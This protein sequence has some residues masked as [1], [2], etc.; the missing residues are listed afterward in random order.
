MFMV[1]GELLNEP[2][3]ISDGLL[4]TGGAEIRAQVATWTVLVTLDVP[5]P[6]RDLHHKL[7]GF[8]TVLAKLYAMSPVPA[9]VRQEWEQR[10]KD[11]ELSMSPQRSR[12]RTKR[13]LF[14]IIGKVSTLLFGTANEDQVKEC[15]RYI[16]KARSMS[17]QISHAVTDLVTV[18]NQSHHELVRN[19][20][21]LRAVED[22]VTQLKSEVDQI[23]RD[24]SVQEERIRRIRENMRIAQYL[25]ALESIHNLWLRSHDRY[26][27]QRASLELGWLTEEI[28]PPEE[29][30]TILRYGQKEGLYSPR[31]EWYYEHVPIKPLWSDEER[32]VFEVG[33]PF[34]NNVEYLRYRIWTWPVPQNTSDFAIQMQSPADVAVD[35]QSGGIFEPNSCIGTRPA[36]CRTGAVYGKGKL[37]CPRGIISGDFNQR[38]H[39]KLTVTQ[40]QDEDSFATELIPGLFVIYTIGEDYVTYCPGE[41]EQRRQLV[42]GLYQLKVRAGCRIVGRDWTIASM[43]QRSSNVTLQLPTV[44]IIPMDLPKLI[45]FSTLQRQLEKPEWKNLPEIKDISIK[46]LQIDNDLSEPITWGSHGGH[47]A[48]TLI[49]VIIV[50]VLILCGVGLYVL[51]FA[52]FKRGKQVKVI[53]PRETEKML[54]REG[55]TPMEIDSAWEELTGVKTDSV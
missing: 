49:I 47:V 12:A 15:R 54:L 14:D 5:E 19:R 29:L 1:N 30:R 46:Q 17:R 40:K 4:V 20:K 53:V 51:W 11:I 8:R 33:I 7:H 13:G 45:P 24:T 9:A 10:I 25:D 38:K 44:P 42:M 43:L 50:I 35:T 41:P 3:Q 23:A 36:V 31:A 21:H 48:W 28:L 16:E 18:V 6:E 2:Q 26:V 37:L 27:R 55:E 32:L 52:K 34:V 39:C 22:Y